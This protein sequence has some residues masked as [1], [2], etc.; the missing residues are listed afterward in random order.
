MPRGWPRKN[1]SG[2]W[3]STRSGC[4]RKNL[5]RFDRTARSRLCKS[6]HQPLFLFNMAQAFWLSDDPRQTIVYLSAV[7]S[8]LNPSAGSGSQGYVAD[9]RVLLIEQ[10]RTVMARRLL[11]LEQARAKQEAELLRFCAAK[12]GRKAKCRTSSAKQPPCLQA[13]MVLGS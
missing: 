7:C 6:I 5:P 3:P 10:E 12:A 2:N 11:E 13:C 9:M 8:S 1:P 4:L